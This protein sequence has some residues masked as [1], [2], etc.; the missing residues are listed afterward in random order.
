M[1]LNQ[2]PPTLKKIWRSFRVHQFHALS[3]NQLTV[4]QQAETTVVKRLPQVK[5]NYDSSNMVDAGDS[6]GCDVD[7]GDGEGGCGFG[8]VSK[9]SVRVVI[10]TTQNDL[11]P[12]GNQGS[13]IQLMLLIFI[14]VLLMISDGEDV[15]GCFG[16]SNGGVNRFGL[17]FVVRT[18]QDDL[19]PTGNCG[20]SNRI[21]VCNDYE[22]HVGD[23]DDEEID[24]G[25]GDV[26]KFG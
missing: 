6:Y 21:D 1:L 3:Q 11:R 4:A 14:D 15:S 9:F 26:D 7:N 23:G 22:S 2:F 25:G 18:T 8:G 12:R 13:M 20:N 24:G 5:G 16:G 17:R 10:K 19:R